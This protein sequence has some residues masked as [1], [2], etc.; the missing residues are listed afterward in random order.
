[1]A[2]WGGSRHD[3]VAAEGPFT[4]RARTWWKALTH[5]GVRAPAIALNTLENH[6]NLLAEKDFELFIKEGL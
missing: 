5:L 4:C 2:A 3:A 6:R 1:M